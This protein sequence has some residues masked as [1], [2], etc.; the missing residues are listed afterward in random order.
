MLLASELKESLCAV[1]AEVVV[2]NIDSRER[3]TNCRLNL[4]VVAF[5]LV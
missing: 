2:L 4:P 5:V 1:L 3:G